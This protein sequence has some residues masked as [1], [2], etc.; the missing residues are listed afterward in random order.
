MYVLAVLGGL[1]PKPIED[2]DVQAYADAL[3]HGEEEIAEEGTGRA[4]ADHGDAGS[5]FECQLRFRDTVSPGRRNRIAHGIPRRAPC[6][7]AIRKTF[8][9]PLQVDRIHPRLLNK[10]QSIREYTPCQFDRSHPEN[11]QQN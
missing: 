6:G 11:R 7:S 8:R 3:G 10:T 4:A 5:V 9:R 1:Y 2:I